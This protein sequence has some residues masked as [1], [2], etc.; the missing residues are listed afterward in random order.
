MDELPKMR[1]PA[2]RARQ[3]AGYRNLGDLIDVERGE[4]A[5]LHGVGP[6]ALRI[7][8]DALE[9]HGRGLA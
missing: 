7:L 3:A 2:P 9:E 5:P 8:D 4:L 6:K 1:A